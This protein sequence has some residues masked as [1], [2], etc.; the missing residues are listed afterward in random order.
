MSVNINLKDLIITSKESDAFFKNYHFKS[1]ADSKEYLGELFLML[2]I[3]NAPKSTAAE[4]GKVMFDMLKEVYFKSGDEGTAYEK[5]EEA[6]KQ[7]NLVIQKTIGKKNDRLRV[8]AVVGILAGSELHLSQTG[9]AEAYLVRGSTFTFI[10]E[11]LYEMSNEEEMFQNIASGLLEDGDKLIFSSERLLRF[12]SQ[13]ELGKIFQFEDLDKSLAEMKDIISLEG[14]ENI[15]IMAF[16]VSGLPEESAEVAPASTSPWLARVQDWARNLEYQGFSKNLILGI[17]GIIIVVLIFTFWV[18]GSSKQIQENQQ[19]VL[20]SIRQVEVDLDNANRLSM[21]GKKSEASEI[22]NRAEGDLE[23]LLDVSSGEYRE[24]I[25]MLMDKL[26]TERDLIDEIT[27]IESANT[28]ADLSGKRADV[29]ARGMIN[30]NDDRKYVYDQNALYETILSEVHDPLTIG[31]DISVVD[32]V[33]FSEMGMLAFLTQQSGVVEYDDGIFQFANTAEEE[34]WKP[35]VALATWSKYLYLLDPSEGDL[36]QIWK[37][38]RTRSGYRAPVAYSVD[39]DL[40]KA[41]D[42]AIDGSLWILTS[43]GLIE[44]LFKGE[45]QDVRIEDAP[46]QGL[47][48]PTKIFTGA[49]LKNIYVLDSSNQ[50]VVSYYKDV[51]DPDLLVYYK[52]YD[53]SAVAEEV[54]DI[55]VN[56]TEQKIYLLTPKQ[57]LE[58]EI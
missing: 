15:N 53:Y 26:D 10:S 58:V 42:I 7:T 49:D 6:L 17:A 22:L 45:R 31:E 57:I 34:G 8:N 56:D 55:F 39:A 18:L 29:Q 1:T 19:V 35:A 33:N 24:N 5:F 54:R 48:S 21:I 16:D 3:L 46:S 12:A 9:Y 27:R 32:G 47:S 23:K 40:S 41:T 43:D 37:Y 13:N 52:Q 51:S 2:E 20:E 36:G 38:E 28:L 11:G 25:I 14:E 30:G 44:K 4:V 50:R